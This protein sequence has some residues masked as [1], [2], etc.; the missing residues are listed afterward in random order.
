MDSPCKGCTKRKIGCHNVETC[1]PWRAYVEIN[2]ARLDAK[3][4]AHEEFAA[5]KA[6]LRRHGY[7]RP[8]G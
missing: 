8:K 4:E 6:H 1:K 7:N 5:V 2:K 3:N